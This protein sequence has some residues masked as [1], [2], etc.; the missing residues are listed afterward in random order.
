MERKW[1]ISL[2]GRRA[3]A[4]SLPRSQFAGEQH[5]RKGKLD[6]SRIEEHP[7]SLV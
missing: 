2:Q 5:C 1:P 6:L 3:A 7:R 4:A